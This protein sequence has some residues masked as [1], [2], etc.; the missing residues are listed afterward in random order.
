[1]EFGGVWVMMNGLSGK[2]GLDVAAACLRK[3]F[4]IAPYAMSGSGSGEVKI[5][6]LEV[7]R[8]GVRNRCD[9]P[10]VSRRRLC[11]RVCVHIVCFFCSVAVVGSARHSIHI[12]RQ[13]LGLPRD[14]CVVQFFCFVVVLHSL[15]RAPFLP[16]VPLALPVDSCGAV[17]NNPLPG[18]LPLCHARHLQNNSDSLP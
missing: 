12:Y 4:R 2:M 15:F 11:V 18:I 5:S 17:R 7:G 6:D 3:G 16:G 13:L 9:G 8:G 14:L 1:M 10:P